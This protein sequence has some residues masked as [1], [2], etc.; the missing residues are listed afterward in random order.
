MTGKD[1][2]ERA[3]DLCALRGENDACSEDT[4]DLK[5]RATGLLNLLLSELHPLNERLVGRKS[6]IQEIYSLEETLDVCDAIG[7]GLIPYALAALL[8]AQE[9]AELYAVLQSHAQ[10][11]KASLLRDGASRRHGIVEVYG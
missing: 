2:F 4:G 8:I 11:V 3:M 1:A 10:E 7:T 5:S 9:D 6:P